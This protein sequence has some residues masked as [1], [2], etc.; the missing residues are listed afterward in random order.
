MRPFQ[1]IRFRGTFRDYQQAVLRRADRHLRDGRIHIVAAP[2]SGKTILG[3]ELIRRLGA[4][5][6]VLS[7][8]VTI[9]QQW[10][11]RFA[12]RFLPEGGCEADYVSYDLRRPAPIT[13]VTYQALHAAMTRQALVAGADED[14]PEQETAEDFSDFDLLA[15][16]RAA[17]V[18]T[19]CLDEAHHLRSEWQK[20]LETFSAALAGQVKVIALTATPPYDST[21]AEWARYSAL[22]GEIDEEIFVPQLVAQRTLCPHQDYL[23]LSYPT[24][25]ET[26]LLTAHRTRAETCAGTALCDGLVQRLVESCGILTGNTAA[27]D[28][29]L[30]Y[31]AGLRSLLSAAQ[32]AGLP[33]PEPVRNLACAGGRLPVCDLETAET[34]FQ[35]IL[36][37]PELFDASAAEELRAR[38]A[39]EGLIEKRRVC[40]VSTERLIR[41]LAASLGKLDSIAAIVR[42]EH[43]SLGDGLRQLILTD[44]IKRD[45]LRLVGTA[46]PVTAMGA[47]PIF[48][49][50]RRACPEAGLR[51]GLLSGTLVLVPQETAP[52][53]TAI[54]E[55][56]G[57]PCRAQ[58]IGNSAHAELLLSGSNRNKVAVVTEAFRQGL[59]RVLVGTKS[60]LGEGW[61]SPC[62]NSLILASFVGSFMLSNQMRG[63]AIRTDASQPDKASNIFHLVTLD[64][65]E[66]TPSALPL[67]RREAGAER[68]AGADFAA[69]ERRFACFLAP[70][71]HRDVIESGMERIDIL[72]P[73]FTP[74]GM[75]EINAEMFALAADRSGMAARWRSALGGDT[76][77]EVLDVNEIPPDAQPKGFLCRNAVSAA[78]LCALLALL[79][80][81]ATGGAPLLLRIPAFVA[82]V[83]AAG[84][85]L[86]ALVRILRVRTPRQTLH[87]LLACLLRALEETDQI[88]TRGAR[89]TVGPGPGG[90]VLYCMLSGAT[91]HEKRVFSTAASELLSAVN[92]PRY[93]LV[94]RT[95]SGLD[96]GQCFACPAVLGG[97]KETA[98]RLAALLGRTGSRFDAVY[99]RGNAGAQALRLCRRQSQRSRSGARVTAKKVARCQRVSGS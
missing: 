36:D 41:Q 7:P 59:V 21:P 51:L 73:P 60:L 81:P 75:A 44:Y 15:A 8:S 9:R 76:H 50:L 63:R 42:A 18:R 80:L 96:W 93:L 43:A 65:P 67:L 68:P 39:G 31:P 13:S 57:V 28:A 30:A 2:G 83:L 3:L 84:L 87:T 64:P 27:E 89:L 45:L 92:D 49:S 61:D 38:L 11:E 33:I 34:A 56:M 16:V 95:R 5:A 4:P 66:A 86:R 17:G 12:E 29:L 20:A 46:E 72:R 98:A 91:V 48:E 77:P 52:A 82:S 32:A 35:L 37:H 97:K 47:V 14:A 10:G 6:L 70:A 79:L 53:I 99:T 94:R 85:L 19:L 74:A 71:Y 26:A 88:A 62:I 69:I 25:E 40:L 78:F 55:G 22:C 54:A 90:G 58:P 23:L 24:A 1:A